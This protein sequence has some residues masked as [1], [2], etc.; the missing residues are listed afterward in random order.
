M[1]F[2]ERL[3]KLLSA[4]DHPGEC[5]GEDEDCPTCRPISC[6]EAYE[7]VY[8]YLDGEL[9][10]DAHTDVQH[11]FSVCK[12]CYPH[13]RFEEHFLDLLHRSRGK[14]EAPAQL[15]AQVLELLAAEAGEKR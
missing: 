5:L 14:E 9:D 13:L 10:E 12:K 2:I 6:R 1:N 15:K 8:E 11:H 3:R 7:R 4:S